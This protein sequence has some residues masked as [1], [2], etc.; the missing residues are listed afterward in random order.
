ME[1]KSGILGIQMTLWIVHGT[2]YEAN[3]TVDVENIA[4]EVLK[5]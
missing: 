1:I 3:S 2:L 4:D 5:R